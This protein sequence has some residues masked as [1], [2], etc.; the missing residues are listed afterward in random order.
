MRKVFTSPDGRATVVCDAGIIRDK[1]S[2]SVGTD[3][4]ATQSV[5]FVAQLTVGYSQETG[6]WGSFE[7]AGK[8]YGARIAF[9]PKSR[10]VIVLFK[11]PSQTWE[12]AERLALASRQAELASEYLRSIGLPLSAV[13][14]DDE[15][16][17]DDFF[18]DDDEDDDDE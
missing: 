6:G 13:D 16:E 10:N 18:D 11:L 1:W 4:V 14:P 15:W 5:G 3:V 8:G 17:D 9:H 7:L 12:E 2:L